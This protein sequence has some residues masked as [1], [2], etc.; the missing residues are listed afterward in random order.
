MSLFLYLS[1]KLR[2]RM[3]A[4]IWAGAE[5]EAQKTANIDLKVPILLLKTL[6]ALR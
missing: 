3:K 1:A 4:R 6:S 2:T 5:K